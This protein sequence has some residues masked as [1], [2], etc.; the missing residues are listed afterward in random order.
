M[1]SAQAGSSA[2]DTTAADRRSS[3]GGGLLLLAGASTG[4]IV[5][6]ACFLQPAAVPDAILFYVAAAALIVGCGAPLVSWLCP[7][8]PRLER[9]G[10][11]LA[12]GL[13]IA[14][15]LICLFALLE[16]SV[17]F[18]PLAFAASGVS[19]ARAIARGLLR[20]PR[21]GLWLALVPLALAAM[22]GWVSAGRMTM[23]DDR[24]AL[25]RQLRHARPQLTT[26]RFRHSS[27]RRPGCPPARRSMP[28]TASSTRISRSRFSV[29]STR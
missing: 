7:D 5:W 14:P 18:P 26:R 4:L 12:L 25:H 2:S 8:A 23:T 15:A 13:A 6:L 20:A 21:Q 16:I 1:T 28:G 11:S 9:V 29:P 27:I 22:T 24:I 10:L 17:L 19:I 3:R